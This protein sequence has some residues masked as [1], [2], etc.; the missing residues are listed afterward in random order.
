MARA[1]RPIRSPRTDQGMVGERGGPRVTARVEVPAETALR[2]ERAS[3]PTVSAW[4]SA[5]AGAGKT[6][7]LVRRVIRLLLGG[8]SPARILCLTFTKAA[9][10]NMANKVLET[11][12]K[13]VRLDDDALDAAIREVSPRAPTTKVRE[14]ARRLFAQALETPAGSRCRRSMHSAIA[15]CISFPWKHACRRASRCW[16][17]C[18]RSSFCDGRARRCW[19]RRPTIRTERSGAPLPSRLPPRPTTVSTWRSP[20]RCAG[21]ASSRASRRWAATPQ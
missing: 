20:N 6:T 5:N 4:V 16:T 18:R 7:V 19:L 3:D 11:L 15:C 12:S 13:W 9:A 10:A 2:Q 1:L 21:D 14:T 17:K 8:N